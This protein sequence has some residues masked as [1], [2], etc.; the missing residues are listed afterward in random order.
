MSLVLVVNPTYIIGNQ[1]KQ[2]FLALAAFA[3]IASAQATAVVTPVAKASAVGTPLPAASA[4]V[5]ATVKA[6]QVVQ[7]PKT[8]ASAPKQ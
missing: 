6:K 7:K 1:M 8:A 3:V 2:L 5:A 4:P